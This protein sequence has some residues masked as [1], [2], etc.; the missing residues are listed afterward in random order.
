MFKCGFAGFEVH[1]ILQWDHTKPQYYEIYNRIRCFYV[2]S[3]FND[4]MLGW[5]KE[6]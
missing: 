3:A 6:E 5:C 2:A 1:L 4:R